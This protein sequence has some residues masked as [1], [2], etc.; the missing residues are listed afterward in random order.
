M[1]ILNRN[2]MNKCAQFIFIVIFA[3]KHIVIFNADLID[4]SKLK[5]HVRVILYE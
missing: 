1:K 4:I 3:R 5:Q 2:E